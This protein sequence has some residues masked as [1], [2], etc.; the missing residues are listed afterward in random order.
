MIP[1]VCAAVFLLCQTA[2]G[3]VAALPESAFETHDLSLSG[4]IAPKVPQVFTV[5]G[6]IFLHR[7]DNTCR[8]SG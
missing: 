8:R 6:T 3:I 7:S 5:K 2:T 4:Q 1:A